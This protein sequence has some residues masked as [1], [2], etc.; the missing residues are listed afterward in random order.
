MNLDRKLMAYAAGAVAAGFA[1]AESADAAI[2]YTPGPFPYAVDGTVDINFDQDGTTQ[3][4]FG[5]G[6]E[7]DTAGNANT[8]RVLLKEDDNGTNNEGYVVG[9]TNTLPAPVAAGNLIGP[10]NFYGNGFLNHTRDQIADEDFDNNDALD[11]PIVTNFA[12][13]NVVGNTQYIGVRFRVN[14]TGD[15][16]YG[17]IGIDITNAADLT[18][19]VTGY[20][21]EDTGEPIAAGAVPEPAG[22]ALLAI[23]SVGLLRRK[24]A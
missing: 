16:R 9:E 13:D 7:R 4:D 3:R 19:V 17:W 24:R 21:F 22:L 10:D 15:D 12:I 1:G 18:G 14:D 5:I 20:A 11:D 6:H 8:D 2:I 23:G